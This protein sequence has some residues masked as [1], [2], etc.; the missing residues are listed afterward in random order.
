M[1]STVLNCQGASA[2]DDGIRSTA[3]SKCKKLIWFTGLQFAESNSKEQRYM[4][5]TASYKEH[6]LVAVASAREKAPSIVPV[7]VLQGVTD[8]EFLHDLAKM[9]VL[10][11]NHTVSFHKELDE[12]RPNLVPGLRGSY[13]RV[14]IPPIV[15]KAR[16]LVDPSGVD[17][18]FVLWTD[19][20]VMF[21][22][23]IDACTLPK[24]HILSAAPELSHGDAQ[25]CGVMYF[26][27]KNYATIHAGMMEWAYADKRFDFLAA[28][29][30]LLQAYLG[31]RI[32]Q[33]PDTFNWKLYW[34]APTSTL[35]DDEPPKLHILHFH[36]SKLTEASCATHFIRE[37]VQEQSQLES[38]FGAGGGWEATEK[39]CL[40]DCLLHCDT[41]M[42][43]LA[44]ST[45]SDLGKFVLDIESLFE[46]YA[47]KLKKA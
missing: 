40:A 26:N 34:G 9:G 33:L 44:Q 46:D 25:N 42:K 30:S 12:A 8:G 17:L 4:A 2:E 39:K 22:S 36:G 32:S 19:P 29:Q 15:A 27:V 31:D 7:A 24:P 16:E 41:L 20:D 38:W 23:D 5:S 14:D 35:G 37:H 10:L 43:L 3:G 28:D 11:L 47:V 21:F 6:Y 18:D 45:L 13:L 1:I